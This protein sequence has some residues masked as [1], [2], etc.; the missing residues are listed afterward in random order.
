[1]LVL[2]ATCSLSQGFMV[3]IHTFPLS[4]TVTAPGVVVVQSFKGRELFVLRAQAV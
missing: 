4:K 1:M 2:S 3:P